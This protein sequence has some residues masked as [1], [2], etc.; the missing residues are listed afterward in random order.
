MTDLSHDSTLAALRDALDGRYALERALGSG[1]MGQVFLARDVTL[2]RPVAVKVISPELGASGTFRDRFLLE[3]RT[4]ANLRHPNIVAVYAAGEAAGHLY[5]AMEYV[6]GESLR[7]LIDREKRV[8]PGRA[9]AILG[10]VA[11]AL[12]YA[13]AQGVIH[14]DVKPENVLIDGQTGRAMLTDFGIARALS[15]AE[16]GGSPAPDSSSG[17][18]AI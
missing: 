10:D 13:H 5:F 8:E 6:A 1:A 18:H 7:D 14:R 2:Q 17:R 11:D 12:A 9:A 4:V 15:V 16:D 3:A